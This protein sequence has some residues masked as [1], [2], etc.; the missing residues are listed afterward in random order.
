MTSSG[1]RPAPGSVGPRLI[2]A[3]AVQA[4]V[5]L[6]LAAFRPLFLGNKHEVVLEAT[7]VEA[8]AAEAAPTTAG[9]ISYR[10]A[11]VP[12]PK[13]RTPELRAGETVYATLERTGKFWEVKSL[14]TAPPPAE[15]P[16]L[17]GRVVDVVE[18]RGY[19]SQGV[20]PDVLA[21]SPGA[22]PPTASPFP[23]AAGPEDSPRELPDR[24]VR[25]W[26]VLIR[27]AFEIEGPPQDLPSVDDLEA[28]QLGEGRAAAVVA[29]DS[30]CRGVLKAVHP[31]RR[32]S[33]NTSP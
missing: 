5:L 9:N 29:V 10:I 16:C 18:N 24:D 19:Y 3:G 14:D 13:S 11:L 33:S 8:H 26:S 23:Q 2:A 12:G 1:K 15:G 4:A 28:D 25:R 20:L 21:P 17:R 7:L 27:V 31:E 30:E 6:S 32:S 22:S